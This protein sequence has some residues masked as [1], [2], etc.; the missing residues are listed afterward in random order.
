LGSALIIPLKAGED[1]I[2]TIK[3]YEPKRKL[4]STI[5]MSMAEGIAQLLS[6]QVLYGDYQ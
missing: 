3:L 4:F 2:G 1:V 6:S 5:N